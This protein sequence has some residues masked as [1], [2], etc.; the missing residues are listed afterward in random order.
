MPPGE[1]PSTNVELKMGRERPRPRDA[2]PAPRRSTGSLTPPVSLSLSVT[3][4][5]INQAEVASAIARKTASIFRTARATRSRI[6][7]AAA[8]GTDR[9]TARDA[10]SRRSGPILREH[11]VRVKASLTALAACAALTR[12]RC[13]HGSA[14]IGATTDRADYVHGPSRFQVTA[15]V[16]AVRACSR[17]G[18]RNTRSSLTTSGDP[19]RVSQQ[20]HEYRPQRLWLSNH[21][22]MAGCEQLSIP[23]PA[24][25]AR[26]A[27]SEKNGAFEH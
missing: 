24:R 14:I 21:R 18:R 26:S 22:V 2:I 3:G 1:R 7:C 20:L 12:S 8:S 27:A 11:R 10:I 9:F 17:G 15:N 5:G 4:A 23:E 6:G 19:V 13:S 25:F 16:A